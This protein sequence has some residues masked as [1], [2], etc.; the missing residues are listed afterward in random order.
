M[1][2][3]SVAVRKQIVPI[4]N[5]IGVKRFMAKVYTKMGLGVAATMGTAL[6]LAPF[7]LELG[8]F[9]VGVVGMFGSIY[10]FSKYSP[11]HHKSS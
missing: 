3:F 11:T 8:A 4:E 10:A 2:A 1:R 6:T 9:G 7:N 5:G